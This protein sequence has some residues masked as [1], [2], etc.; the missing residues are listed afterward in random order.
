VLENGSVSRVERA[1]VELFAT[2]NIFVV[3]QDVKLVNTTPAQA[4]A[5]CW[6]STSSAS[7]AHVK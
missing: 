6:P 3:C 1:A 5:T 2:R 7:S 4:R